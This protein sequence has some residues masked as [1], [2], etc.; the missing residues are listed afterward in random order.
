[1]IVLAPFAALVAATALVGLWLNTQTEMLL[2]APPLFAR[3][4]LRIGIGVPLAAVV[5]YVTIRLGARSSQT[6]RRSVWIFV[7]ASAAWGVG[8]ALV[9]GPSGLER[10]ITDP[11]GYYVALDSYGDAATF[12]SNFTD[13]IST[14]PVHVRGHPPGVPLLLIALD[15]LG[16]ASVGVIAALLV[17]ASASIVAAVMLVVRRLS[18]ESTAMAVAPFIAL[19]PAAI[20]L[21]NSFDALFAAIGAWGIAAIVVP[22]RPAWAAA[23]GLVFGAGIFA[24]YGLAPLVLVPIILCL[25]RG[26]RTRLT[27]AALGGLAVVVAFSLGGFWWVEGLFATRLEYA[28]S[29]AQSRPYLYFLFAN[30]AAFGLAVGVGPLRGLAALGDKRVWLLCGSALAVVAL[31]NVSGLSKGEVERIW[32]PFWPWVAVAAVGIAASSRRRWLVA[33]AGAAIVLQAIIWVPW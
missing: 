15:R 23:G 16:L 31:A 7:A 13:E 20:W 18:D 17:G 10:G 21:V 25:R 4:D 2:N 12:L 8:L 11:F 6:F 28:S 14:Y 5:A 22:K 32:L 1:M 29:V 3:P 27:Y 33:H 24:S 19:A 9:D 26:E 30:I